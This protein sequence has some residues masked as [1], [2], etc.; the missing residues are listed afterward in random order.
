M[1]A[2]LNKNGKNAWTNQSSSLG[3]TIQQ[4]VEL[5][6]NKVPFEGIFEGLTKV[7][8]EQLYNR[9]QELRESQ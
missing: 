4:L 7:V 6:A 5:R 1:L 2:G 9:Q 3:M 8:Q